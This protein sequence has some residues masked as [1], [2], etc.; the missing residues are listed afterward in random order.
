MVPAAL[1]DLRIDAL[2]EQE[3]QRAFATA[4]V[5]FTVK[6]VSSELGWYWI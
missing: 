5:C 2:R 4:V 3:N 6:R 1:H